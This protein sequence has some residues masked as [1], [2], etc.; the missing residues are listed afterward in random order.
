M[1]GEGPKGPNATIVELRSNSTNERKR[2]L[3]E[4]GPRA[5]LAARSENRRSERS[6]HILL[7]ATEGRE[8]R[9]P[10]RSRARRFQINEGEA[11]SRTVTYNLTTRDLGSALRRGLSEAEGRAAKRPR[12][13]SSRNHS[14]RHSGAS[15][16]F[17]ER[18]NLGVRSRNGEGGP[19]GRVRP[20]AKLRAERPEP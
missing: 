12:T 16:G 10:R 19:K 15:H 18:R 4:S 11:E 5:L 2:S 13:I 17:A 6:Y 8:S 20:G 14:H 1:R 9:R 7:R 3:R